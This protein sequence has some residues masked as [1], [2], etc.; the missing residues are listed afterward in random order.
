MCQNPTKGSKNSSCRSG[1]LM[2]STHATLEL[3]CIVGLCRHCNNVPQTHCDATGASVESNTFRGS[4]VL[5]LLCHKPEHSHVAVQAPDIS[6][7]A[8]VNADIF[9]RS[10]SA[11]ADHG[12]QKL[13]QASSIVDMKAHVN[14][15]V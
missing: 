8:D 7:I 10:V 14:S 2:C 1:P 4:L 9:S 11:P 5:E 3:K 13:N 6:H 15:I 12:R